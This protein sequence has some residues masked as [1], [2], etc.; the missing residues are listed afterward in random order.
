MRSLDIWNE[1]SPRSLIQSWDLFGRDFDRMLNEAGK[2]FENQSDEHFLAPACDVKESEGAYLMSFDLPGI[3]QD[4][5]DV[6]VQGQTLVVTA[7]RHKEEQSTGENWHRS[8]RHHGK[9]RRQFSL[10][11]TVDVSQI[12]ADYQDGVLKLALPKKEANTRKKVTIGANSGGF[13][14]RLVHGEKS[15]KKKSAVNE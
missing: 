12:E 1:R 13:L 5:I 3:A 14:K 9:F 8:E 11:E 4:N 6:E 7:E 15:T 2:I 10:P